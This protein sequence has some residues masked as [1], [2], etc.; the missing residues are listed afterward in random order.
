MQLVM[1]GFPLP[2]DGPMELLR[3]GDLIIVGLRPGSRAAIMVRLC[4]RPVANALRALQ[5]GGHGVCY[6]SQDIARM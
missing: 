5:P 6:P 4:E 2:P 3:D 1:D